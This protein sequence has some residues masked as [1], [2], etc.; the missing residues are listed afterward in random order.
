[1]KK[2]PIGSVTWMDL[3]VPNADTIRDFYSS[4]AGWKAEPVGMGDYNDYNMTEPESGKPAAGVCHAR[5][6]NT[7]MPAQW[8][9]Y[10]NVADIEEST[11]RCKEL[12]G[13][14]V[15]EIRSAGTMGKYCVI[16]DPAGAVVA[17]FEQA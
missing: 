4:V 2:N 3:T 7:G 17:L 12:G 5:G 15:T 13:S 6:M 16:R 8:M 14:M 1:M 9:M 11:R 10:I